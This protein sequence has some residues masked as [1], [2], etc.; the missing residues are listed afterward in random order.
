MMD[1]T[2]TDQAVELL[3]CGI[4]DILEETHPITVEVLIEGDRSREAVLTEAAEDILALTRA[5]Q[6]I[7][8]RHEAAS[9]H[10]D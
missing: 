7:R 5:M 1:K 3:S 8:R 10:A 6:V 9:R 2:Y 4:A